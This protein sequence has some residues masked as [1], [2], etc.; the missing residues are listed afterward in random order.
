MI[1]QAAGAGGCS[2]RVRSVH[3]G[4][5]CTLLLLDLTPAAC[6]FPLA[7]SLLLLLL[8]RVQFIHSTSF[9]DCLPSCNLLPGRVRQGVGGGVATDGG[10][11]LS[12]LAPALHLKTHILIPTP[13]IHSVHQCGSLRIGA[14]THQSC[15]GKTLSA[16]SGLPIISCVMCSSACRLHARQRPASP[17][18]IKPIAL[19]SHAQVKP[20]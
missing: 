11:R 9:H 8:A 15:A 17:G 10:A 14:W 1:Q 12:A 3:N 20:K 2:P 19:Q 18:R 6:P 7:P 4:C 5:P 16:G 13:A